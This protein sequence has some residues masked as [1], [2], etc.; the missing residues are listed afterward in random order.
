MSTTF[1]R[2][3]DDET[4]DSLIHM[5]QRVLASS[6]Y[7]FPIDVL[8]DRLVQY[9]GDPSSFHDKFPWTERFV[10][11]IPVPTWARPIVWNVGQMARFISAIWSG[12]HL[13]SYLTNEWYE[14]VGAGRVLAENSEVLLDGQQRLHSL[15][16]YFLD[17]LAVPDIQG[18]PRVWSELGNVER[19]RFL[20]TI[21][22][23]SSVSSDDEMALRRT[24]DLCALG[25]APHTHDQRAAR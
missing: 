11:G 13:G 5:P 6:T 4:T 25:V 20:S 14:S 8:A 12:A 7:Q 15:E 9:L 18:Q 17:R 22:P 3:G 23:H 21:F 10:M 19:K 16:E 1:Q 24:Y 2:Y